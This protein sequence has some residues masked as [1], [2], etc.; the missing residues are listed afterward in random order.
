LS[1]KAAGYTTSGAN[2]RSIAG[3]LS[4]DFPLQKMAFTQTNLWLLSASGKFKHPPS[5][6]FSPYL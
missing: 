6:D 2:G 5:Y 4:D 3:R 1:T